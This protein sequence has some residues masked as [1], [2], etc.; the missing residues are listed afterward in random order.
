M[1]YP[2]IFFETGPL[3]VAQVSLE[4]PVWPG[5]HETPGNQC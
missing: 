4:L 1:N 5:S 3:T 2:F